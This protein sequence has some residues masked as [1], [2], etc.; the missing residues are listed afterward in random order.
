M[1]SLCFT[2]LNNNGISTNGTNK[3]SMKVCLHLCISLHFQAL[4]TQLYGSEKYV[5][6]SCNRDG[7]KQSIPVILYGAK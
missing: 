7:N 1:Y 5:R 4:N 3:L 2:K 6:R